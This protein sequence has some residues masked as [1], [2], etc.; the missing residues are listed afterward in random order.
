MDS[1]QLEYFVTSCMVPYT[2]FV[3][4]VYDFLFTR[5]LLLKQWNEY[6]IIAN[7]TVKF[8]IIVIGYSGSSDIRIS[9]IQHL[10]YPN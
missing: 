4:F 2:Q 1:E 10:D 3:V 8:K 5:L 9:V 6:E 7:Y